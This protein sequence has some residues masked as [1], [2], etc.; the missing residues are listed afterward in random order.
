MLAA[1]CIVALAT[2][3]AEIT[4]VGIV[5]VPVNA[6]LAFGTF[7]VFSVPSVAMRAAI[8][9]LVTRVASTTP[10]NKSDVVSFSTTSSSMRVP[11]NALSPMDVTLAGIVRR[12]VI[13][14]PLNALA[15]MMT[16]LL[17]KTSWPSANS[18][19]PLNA[20]LAISTTENAFSKAPYPL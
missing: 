12:P 20:P 7:S 3:A 5:V 4:A 15:P 11:L 1:A 10:D 17:G 8:S 14:T 18:V 6:G 16:R 13:F 19:R 9:L 2:V